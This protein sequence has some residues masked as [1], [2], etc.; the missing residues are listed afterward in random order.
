MAKRM[1]RED[2]LEES[3]VASSYT[4]VE[5]ITFSP[6][7]HSHSR[8]SSSA[9]WCLPQK[10]KQ[11]TSPQLVPARR[12]DNHAPSLSSAGS[13]H[14]KSACCVTLAEATMITLTNPRVPRNRL[15]TT[16]LLPDCL[17]TPM[18]LSLYFPPDPPPPL[19]FPP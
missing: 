5:A 14:P 17:S 15:N 7:G 12:L 1:P 18:I 4:E 16:S 10:Q 6:T 9:S 3:G 13:L 8:D 11:H 19:S 2:W